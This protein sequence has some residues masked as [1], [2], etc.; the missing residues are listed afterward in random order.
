LLQRNLSLVTSAATR[1]DVLEQVTKQDSSQPVSI[2]L[3]VGDRRDALSCLP[4]KP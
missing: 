4:G 3:N 1:E 2:I